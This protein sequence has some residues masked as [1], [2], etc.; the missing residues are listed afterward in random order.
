MITD[1]AA[2]CFPACVSLDGGV[3]GV[4]LKSLLDHDRK[5]SPG[6]RVPLVFQKVNNLTDCQLAL[7]EQLIRLEL[8]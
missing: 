1:I 5:T 7:G 6:V 8:G 3:F 4:P 2:A